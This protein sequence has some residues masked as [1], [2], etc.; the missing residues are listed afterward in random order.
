MPQQFLDG[1]QVGAVAE[2]MRRV[3]VAKTMRMN[4]RVA[5]DHARVK[6]H[7]AASAA[8]AQAHP[9]MIQEQRAAGRWRGFA[10]GEVSF[11]SVGRFA[12]ERNLPLLAAFTA[13]ADPALAKIEVLE[14]Q[15][16]QFA[17][18]QAAAV[19]QLEDSDVTRRIGPLELLGGLG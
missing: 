10:Y 11:E 13:H 6:F 7:N 12:S 5:S 1:A 9:P 14:I 8:I 15:A 18:A 17:D 4:G 3:G 19:E 16:R 2:Q